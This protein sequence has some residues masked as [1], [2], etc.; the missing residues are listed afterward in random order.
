MQLVDWVAP[1]M[2]FSA[3]RGVATL[4][5]TGFLYSSQACAC[6]AVVV[7][8][9]LGGILGCSK[10]PFGHQNLHRLR[11]DAFDSLNG[12][13]G[14]G[15][16]PPPPPDKK[17]HRRREGKIKKITCS[18]YNPSTGNNNCNTMHKQHAGKRNMNTLFSQPALT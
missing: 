16:P 12:F 2:C 8:V 6:I 9:A 13:L 17:N 11:Q 14:R 1:S 4:L 15:P 18:H 7:W 3:R 5:H 10:N